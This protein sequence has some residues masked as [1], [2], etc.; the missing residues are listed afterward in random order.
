MEITDITGPLLETIKNQVNNADDPN[1]KLYILER[2]LSKLKLMKD[3]VR[4]S[5]YTG[6]YYC[7]KC[8]KYYHQKEVIHNIDV[9][10]NPYG[11]RSYLSMVINPIYAAKHCDGIICEEETVICPKCKTLL[12]YDKRYTLS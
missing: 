1:T 5:N 10:N 8:N 2:Y 4:A 6:W 7:P 3:E 11:V 9:D 12:Y